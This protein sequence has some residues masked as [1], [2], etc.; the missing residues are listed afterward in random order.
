MHADCNL[1]SGASAR[2]GADKKPEPQSTRRTFAEDAEKTVHRL[3][4]FSAVSAAFLSD[5]C[6]KSFSRIQQPS[7]SR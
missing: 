5:L 6:G 2:G 4:L 1:A 7:H 3:L